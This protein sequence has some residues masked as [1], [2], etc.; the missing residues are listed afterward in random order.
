MKTSSILAVLLLVLTCTIANAVELTYN[1]RLLNPDGDPAPSTQI[2]VRFDV[3]T[4]TTIAGEY[5]YLYQ[6]E[7]DGT[8]NAATTTDADG[9]FQIVLADANTNF[10]QPGGLEAVFDGS[11]VRKCFREDGTTLPDLPSSYPTLEIL[12]YFNTDTTD[13]WDLIDTQTVRPAI[14]AVNAQKLA[15][16]PVSDF[17]LQDGSANQTQFSNFFNGTDFGKLLSFA[18]GG[19]LDLNSSAINNVATPVNA[20]D[21]VNK[22]YA[23]SKIAGQATASLGTLGTGDNGKIMVWTGSAWTARSVADANALPLGGG[24]MGGDI[25]LDGHDLLNT[26]YITMGSG[27]FLMVGNSSGPPASLTSAYTGAIWFDTAADRL[28]YQGNSGV[29][30][31]ISSIIS[32]TAAA[33]LSVTGTGTLNLSIG[34][35]STTDA[36]V[37]RLATDG[38]S[39]A[40]KALAS[41]D[42][43]LSNSRAPSGSASGDLGGSYPSP[44]VAKIRGVAFSSSPPAA[45]MVP[46]L[47][48]GTPDSWTP[49]YL[50][51]TKVKNSSGNSQIPLTCSTGQT[52]IWSSLVNALECQNVAISR[53]QVSGLGTASVQDVGTAAGNVVQLDG[54]AQIVS[55]LLKQ[56]IVRDGGNSPTAGMVIGTKNSNTLQLTT[57]NAVK[58]TV[59]TNGNVGI[60]DTLPAEK[61]SVSGNIKATGSVQGA[62]LVTTSDRRLKDEIRDL[63]GLSLILRLKGHRFIWRD[64]REE[65]I[66]FIAQE[67]EATEPRLV[68]TNPETGLKGVKYSNVVAPLVEA[69]KEI[70]GLCRMAQDQSDRLQREW[71]EKFSRLE[72]ARQEDRADLERMAGRVRQ[73][74]EDNLQLRRDLDQLKEHLKRLAR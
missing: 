64:T 31:G 65:D 15:G 70:Y 34:A 14:E 40:A 35:A 25:D 61:L 59:L 27:K 53:T 52:M 36:G 5:C 18:Q 47:V 19:D 4:A 71:T 28:T 24:T 20:T 13:G 26:G 45:D 10:N 66:G 57:N 22:S 11:A 42:S 30:R 39:S 60:G 32:V 3:R 55:G 38:E 7:Q 67:V 48:T 37:L 2:Y 63:E 41:N 43:R 9:V 8:V 62:T 73:L 58:L 49:S 17:I 1:G 16:R 12:V 69:T 44:S 50:D 21:A 6:F 72:A 54:S 74:E 46:L 56:D 29:L 33:P 51:I 68:V 23:D